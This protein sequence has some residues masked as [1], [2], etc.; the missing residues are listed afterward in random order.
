MT[1]SKVRLAT[2]WPRVRRT[3]LTERAISPPTDWAVTRLE[4]GTAGKLAVSRISTPSRR[5]AL[6]TCFMASGSTAVEATNRQLAPVWW[7]SSRSW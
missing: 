2:A 1:T 5:R 7:T 6:R 3:A 4:E